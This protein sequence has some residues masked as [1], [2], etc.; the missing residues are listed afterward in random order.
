M[1]LGC[2][3]RNTSSRLP[4]FTIAP[5]RAAT[6]SAQG[7]AG[8]PVQTRPARTIKSAGPSACKRRARPGGITLRNKESR[9][10]AL[11]GDGS[12][13][14]QTLAA[15]STRAS[16]FHVIGLAMSRLSLR[17]INGELP[18][19]GQAEKG[20]SLVGGVN[21]TGPFLNRV[22]SK[23]KIEEELVRH[24]PQV[25]RGQLALAL[26]GDPGFDNVLGEHVAL[27]QEFVVSFQGVE[28]L[29]QRAR[30]AFDL[31]GLFGLEVVQV[32]V[33]RIAGVD[34]VLDAIQAGHEHR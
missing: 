8:S 12:P 26:V 31:L 7:L 9:S 18:R 16:P 13:P 25:H 17:A 23:V 11:D 34:L 33:D 6:P 19:S 21:Q 10:A 15:R 5:S 22:G 20:P 27:E 4:T 1:V 14:W 29:A 28:H 32:L 30:G 3:R 24:R 2:L